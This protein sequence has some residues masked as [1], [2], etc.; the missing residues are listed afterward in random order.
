M[1]MSGRLRFLHRYLTVPNVVGAVSPSSAQM[2]EALVAP[3]AKRQEPAC[4][5]EVGAGT[6][7]VTRVIG[8]HLGPADRLDVCEIEP[9]LADVLDREVLNEGPLAAARAEGRVRLIRGPVQQIN[10]P[11]AY[12]FIIAGLP[13]TAF[14]VADVREILRVI[15]RCLKPGGTFSYFEYVGLRRLAC[16]AAM[17][18]GRIRVRRVSAYL[19]RRIA[20]HQ[21]GIATVWRNLPP[22]YARYW[23]FDSPSGPAP[24]PVET[25]AAQS[26][27]AGG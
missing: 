5:L 12:D 25:G 9:A 1:S 15:Q 17:L 13:F 22:A 18:S 20:A 26:S 19:N 27:F 23:Q 21:V 4:V 10:S 7:A 14:T 11:G 2:A 24:A 8:Q 16:A 3:F 6:G